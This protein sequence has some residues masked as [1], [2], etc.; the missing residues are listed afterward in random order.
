MKIKRQVSGEGGVFECPV[1][2]TG[3]DVQDK[4]M[5]MATRKRADQG[6]GFVQCVF[7]RGRGGR[8]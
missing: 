6:R 7:K 5:N 8:F 1:D 2:R 4:G 3:R